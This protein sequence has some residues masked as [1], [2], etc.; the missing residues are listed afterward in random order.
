[1]PVPV[2]HGPAVDGS[3][4]TDPEYARLRE[5]ILSARRAGGR[6]VGSTRLLQR[7]LGQEPIHCLPTLKAHI[8]PDGSMWWPCKPCVNVPPVKI[9][10][11]EH[12]TLDGVWASGRR[13]VDPTGFHGSGP[14]QCGADCGWAQN[15]AADLYAEGLRHPLRLLGAIRDFTAR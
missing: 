11:L 7:L 9:E 8:D 1:V 10:V 14:Q 13:L 5:R 15:Y 6:V 2:N 3:L 12:D 4:L